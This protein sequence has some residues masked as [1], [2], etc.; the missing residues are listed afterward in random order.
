MRALLFGGTF[1][2]PHTGHISLLQN[3]IA[4]VKP[5]EV[6]V[7]P[8]AV[9]PHKAESET[10]A[11]T[12]MA[13]CAC[14]EPLAP[15]VEISDVELRRP[16]RSYTIHTVA[17]LAKTRPERD[18]YLAIGGDMLAGFTSWRRWEE[19]LTR[20]TLVVQRREG[21]GEGLEAEAEAL[22]AAG[23]QVLFTSAPAPEI[24]SSR[25]RAMLAAGDEAAFGYLA[26]PADAIIR[27]RGLY[28]W[29][30]QV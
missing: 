27:A 20:V 18:W 28:G 23:G 17:E 9:P 10:P 26:P 6:L 24:S 5:N 2:P 3:A 11:E 13:M 1:D 16:G 30:T 12:R 29:R 7:V 22:V 15:T 19:L 25:L 4:A 8:A 14:F 21:A